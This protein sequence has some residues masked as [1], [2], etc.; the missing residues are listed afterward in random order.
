MRIRRPPA[1]WLAGLSLL[2]MLVWWLGWYP[3]FA[4]SDTMDQWRQGLTGEYF[5][6]HPPVHT[7]YLEILSLGNTRPGLVT[8]FQICALAGLLVYAAKRLIEAGVPSWLAIGVAWLVGAA[9][10]VVTTTLTLWKDVVFGLCLL[11]AWIE[12]IHLSKDAGWERTW[13][14]VRLGLALAGVWAF[15]GNGPIT[16][17]LL[18]LL[19]AWVHRSRLRR[20]VRLVAVTALTA[21]LL[22]TV[23]ASAIGA[24]GDGI[25]PS[26]VFLPDIAAS[27]NSEPDTFSPE[28]IEL[29]TDLAPLQIWTTRY[30]CYDSTPLLF[31]PSFDHEPLRSNRGAYRSLV[32]AVALRD[33]D[34]VLEHRACVA[35]FLYS[36]AQPDDAYFH[37]PPYE[38]PPN[39]VG[40]ARARKSDRAF[41]VTDAIWRWGEEHLW[42]VWRPALVL[43]PTAVVLA[44][45]ATRRGTR[46]LLLAGLLWVAHLLN[47]ALTSPAQELRYAYPL[48]VIGLLTLPLAWLLFRKQSSL[49]GPDAGH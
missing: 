21:I 28:D 45:L 17:L 49:S 39:T 48:Y 36:P 27:L 2:P 43:I 32:V 11:W 12:L 41:A 22:T 16:V 26:Q 6:H 40:L 24:T 10:A 25:D 15:R 30:T 35:N 34:S 42:L 23:L 31:D 4:S 13:P 18:F 19:L 8:L 14:T 44:A 33:P 3:G 5:N 9:P 46:P 47:V 29:L 20:M 1:H 38:I 37:R 7:I